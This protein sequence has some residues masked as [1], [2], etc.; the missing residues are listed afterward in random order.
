MRRPRPPAAIFRRAAVSLTGTGE[1]AASSVRAA[2]RPASV[3]VAGWMPRASSRS[4]L[5][6]RRARPWPRRAEARRRRA[7][8][9][10]PRGCCSAPW[11]SSSSSWRRCSSAVSTSRR[12]D[13]L[14]C[15]TRARTS[16][17]RRA[18]ATAS[19]VAAVMPDEKVGVVERGRIVD[20]RRQRRAG[21]V[22]QPDC[23]LVVSGREDERPA[24][25][26]R[27]SRSAR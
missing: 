7:A 14:T 10:R 19:L 4:S 17:C 26:R 18:L 22:D 15:S 13:A 21:V 8:R 11:C 12:R 6:R 20:Q 24:R 9:R 16:A 2:L 3:S 25:P 23:S 1:R 5:G 27:R